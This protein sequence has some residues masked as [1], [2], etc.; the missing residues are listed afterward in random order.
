MTDVSGSPAAI[1]ESTFRGLLESA[2]DAMVIVDKE[3]RIVLL[4][5]EAE[6]LFDYERDELI[7][8]PVEI[9]VPE[10]FHGAH[11]GHRRGYLA[12]PTTRPMGV[13]LDL[14]AVRKGGTEFP[15]EIS[16]SPLETDAGVL[17][18]SSIRDLTERRRSDEALR[19]SEMLFRGLLE[20]APDAKVIVDEKSKIVLVNGQTEKLFGYGRDELIGQPVEIL[21]P[22][23]F[24]VAHHGH[25]EAFLAAPEVRPMGTGLNLFGRRKDGTEFPAD[26]SLSPYETSDG[27]LVLSAIRDVTEQKNA[28]V[29]IRRLANE[30]E[31]ANAAKSEFLSRM[32]HELRTPLNAIIGFGQLLQVDAADAEQLDSVNHILR[33][34]RHLLSLV[35]EILDVAQIE[36]G[37]IAISLEPVDLEE[38]VTEAIELV[39]PLAAER[40]V[41]VRAEPSPERLHV[42]ADRQRLLQVILNLLGNA[43]KYDKP[44]GVVEISWSGS[45]AGRVRL[46]VR[47][48][49]P[50]IPAD[51]LEAIFAP[52]E[53]LDHADRDTEG[54]GLGLALAR[55]LVDAMD[56][57]IGAESVPGEGSTFW[58]ELAAVEEPAPRGRAAAAEAHESHGAAHRGQ[59]QRAATRRAAA[60]RP[61]RPS[62][63][64]RHRRDDRDRA[65]AQALPG[66]HPPRSPSSRSPGGGSAPAASPGR[67]HARHADRDPLGRHDAGGCPAGVGGGRERL[68]HEADR[69][70]L[71]RHRRGRADEAPAGLAAADCGDDVE[72]G[73]FLYRRVQPGP[74]AVDVDVE[75]PAQGRPLLDDP[76]AQPRPLRLERV[77]RREHCR[78]L[79]LDP[80]RQPWEERCQ[81]SWEP[82]VR[83]GQSITATSTDEIAGR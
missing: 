55:S 54:T 25:S 52:F 42:L 12:Q 43:V 45:P 48:N 15:V 28:E 62:C 71:A 80:A 51:H 81:R 63:D 2:P 39:G 1:T 11:V 56:G 31:R 76:V 27:R 30:A 58:I 72:P 23:R 75:V 6:R 70:R 77:D 19:R 34:G 29:E 47:D 3:A 50:G 40:P 53:R 33:A 35:N 82:D 17:V 46:A 21:L 38:V 37:K 66:R 20:A 78:G 59:P 57:T 74:L 69:R 49:G 10:R 67:T 14:Y 83:H 44:G 24:R 9:L 8:E 41:G 64:R 18:V 7:G 68:R 16:L 65:G 60:A 22:T 79:D 4:N 26:I 36:A 61:Y 13:D 32:S 5:A 73:P